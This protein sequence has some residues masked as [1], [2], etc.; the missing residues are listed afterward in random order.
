[1]TIYNKSW[2]AVIGLEIHVQLAT[3]SKLFSGAST[4]FGALPNT[5]ACDIDLALPGV[6]PV[7]NE[8]VLKM[9]V[10][11]GKAL[12]ANIN[13][14]TS[15]ARKNYFYPDSP[16]G[17]QISQMDKP[18]VEDGFLDIELEDGSSKRIGITRAH[19]EEDAG[20]S[21]HED[22]EGQSGIDLN[23]AGTPLIE[24]VSEPDISSPEEAVAYLKS[25]HSIIKYLEISDGNMA[26]GSMRCDA[27]VSVRKIDSKDLGTRTE[28]KNVNSF[29]FVE[30]A[31]QYEIE[32]QINEIETGNTI[33]QETRLYDSQLNTT[34]PMRTKEFA[35]DYRYFPEPDL[36][37]VVLE[38]KFIKK[39]LEEMPEM[40]D[41]K[42][43]RFV[44]EY[45]LSE[46]DSS[47]LAADKD[48][49]DFFEIATKE[50]NAAK[51]SANWIMGELSAELNKENL[52]IQDSK[53]TAKQIGKLVL[54]IED[55][56]ISG[57]IAKEIFEK[58]WTTGQ[59]VD[60]VIEEEGLQQVT[61]LSAIESMVNKVIDDNPDQLKQYLA[62][63]D[64]L[65]G[66]FVGQVMKESQG[67]A[68]PAHVNQILKEKLKE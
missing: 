17:Y 34:R 62:G 25:I 10:K 64:R 22:F 47:L 7:L 44:N 36:L 68:N 57:K 15:F 8:E 41:E 9:A 23:R 32:R 50:S 29:R 51:L 19:L 16:K 27:N 66:F 58:M 21:L 52:N 39:V 63:K 18:I 48:L 65:F 38:D 56:T 46:Y 11:L 4:N 61:D 43:K 26:E 37:P 2:E 5:Q 45:N 60:A 14:P 20:K 13:T 24:I 28:T 49:A 55:S 35:N 42:K 67:K 40:P 53:I 31:I 1:M 12:N 30:K 54:R 3:K 59:E 6:L 33:T